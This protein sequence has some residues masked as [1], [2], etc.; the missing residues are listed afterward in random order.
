[1]FH[2]LLCS[3]GK[4]FHPLLCFTGKYFIL[5]CVLQV[6]CFIFHCVIQVNVSCVNSFKG[7]ITLNMFPNAQ[8]HMQRNTITQN[9][10]IKKVLYKVSSLFLTTYQSLCFPIMCSS[11]YCAYSFCVTQNGF[12]WLDS[13]SDTDKSSPWKGCKWKE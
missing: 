3:T 6:S 4:W 13:F 2:P 7:V 5:Y 8:P 11:V 1:M 9:K 12:L 10:D